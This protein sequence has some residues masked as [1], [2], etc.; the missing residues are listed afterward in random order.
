MQQK[1][2]EQKNRAFVIGA[3]IFLAAGYLLTVLSYA[4][5]GRVLLDAD[6][7]SEMVLAR[8]LNAEG[9]FLSRNWFYSTELR[10]LNTQIVNKAALAVFPSDWHAA[11]TLAIAVLML[12]LVASYLY[13][14]W[15]AGLQ[16]WGVWGA[17]ALMY[18]FSTNYGYI[19][20]FGSFYVPHLAILFFALGIFVRQVRG[21]APFSRKRRRFMTAAALLLAFVSGLGGIR[22]FLILYAPLTA[23]AFLVLMSTTQEADRLADV[24]GSAYC[25]LMKAALFPS[26]ACFAGIAVNSALLHRLYHFEKYANIS[27]NSL[28]LHGFW[29]TLDSCLLLWGY[30]GAAELTDITGL[31]AMAGMISCALFVWAFV[32]CIRARSALSRAEM[33]IVLFTMLSILFNTLFYLLA[34]NPVPRYLVPSAVM[35]IPVFTIAVGASEKRGRFWPGAFLALFV[36]C[37][38]IQGTNVFYYEAFRDRGTAPSTN[39]RAARW[40]DE[41]G[42]VQGFASFWNCNDLTELTDGRLEMWDL[43]IPDE[44]DGTLLVND[45]LQPVSHSEQ[46]PTGRTFI[47]VDDK[48]AGKEEYAG[49]LEDNIVNRIDDLTIYGYEDASEL[50]TQIVI[51][52]EP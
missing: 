27:L 35:A 5:N 12:V 26:I 46:L 29:E 43:E 1:S 51:G 17:G 37:V 30:E 49:L 21:D 33:M 31:G 24:R 42:Y 52:K 41:N 40:L 15:G 44:R 3:W 8:L 6:E 22:Q 7:A 25:P 48:E 14:I 28:S 32:L 34:N 20:L 36:L 9:G 39:D 11:R 4:L 50:Y 38:V 23:A 19:V 13:F 2:A 45:W 10:V 47:V 16:R 18:P